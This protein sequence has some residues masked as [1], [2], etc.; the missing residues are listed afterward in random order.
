VDTQFLD[1]MFSIDYYHEM[2][3]INTQAPPAGKMAAF[4]FLS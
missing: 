4:F 1:D 3:N 2:Q